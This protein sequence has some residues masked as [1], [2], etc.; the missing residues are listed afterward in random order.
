MATY[1]LTVIINAN[2]P[3]EQINS[4]TKEVEDY[5]TRSGAEVSNIEVWGKRRLAYLI[6]KQHQGYYV[7]YAFV[8]DSDSA[9]ILDLEQHFR[10]SDDF[11]RSMVVRLDEKTLT[12]KR[13]EESRR[14]KADSSRTRTPREVKPVEKVQES[15]VPEREDEPSSEKPVADQ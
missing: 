3:D 6:K 4:L 2:L 14:E 12:K 8:M 1:E 10:Q 5:L 7:T 11:L 13:K 15:N 9:K